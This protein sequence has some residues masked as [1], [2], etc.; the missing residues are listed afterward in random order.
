MHAL[1]AM[2]IIDCEYQLV[3]D[4][5]GQLLGNATVGVQQFE[6]V[7]GLEVLGDHVVVAAVFEHLVHLHDV[8]VVLHQPNTTSC[9]RI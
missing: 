4:V 1:V 3:K 7:F 9:R 2:Q 8:R 5:A 6:C